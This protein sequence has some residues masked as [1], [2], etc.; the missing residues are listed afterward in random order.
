MVGPD[1][2]N[3]DYFTT[4]APVSPPIEP[5][6]IRK[7][8]FEPYEQ[9][10]TPD[11]AEKEA[12]RCLHCGR[13]IECDNCLVFCPDMSVHKNRPQKFGYRFDYDYCKGCGICF[14]ECPRSAISLTQ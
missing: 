12:A 9:G 10:Y 5:A 2:L 14:S 11:Q 7:T 6:D 3:A 4:V 1:D 8:S 13:C